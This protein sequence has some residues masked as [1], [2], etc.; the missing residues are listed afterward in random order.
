MSDEMECMCQE[1]GISS[2]F[3]ALDLSYEDAPGFTGK[4]LITNLF[5]PQCGGVLFLVGRIDEEPRYRTG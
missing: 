4:R 5:C 1:C 3:S 2:Y